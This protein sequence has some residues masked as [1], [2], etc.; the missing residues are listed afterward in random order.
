MNNK[1]FWRRAKFSEK[2]EAWIDRWEK[3]GPSSSCGD[4]GLRANLW[5]KVKL[6]P[7]LKLT[8][9]VSLRLKVN[10]RLRLYR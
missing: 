9:G 7:R 4:P 3:L 1:I 6:W 8:R 2:L 5:L 10:F